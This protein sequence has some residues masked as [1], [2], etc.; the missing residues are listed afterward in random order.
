MIKYKELILEN[1]VQE[2]LNK[3]ESDIFVFK[4]NNDSDHEV[5]YNNN[6]V[7]RWKKKK[8][9][10]YFNV[11]E[12]S[13]LTIVEQVFKQYSQ[14]SNHWNEDTLKEHAEK[15]WRLIIQKHINEKILYIEDQLHD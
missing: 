6:I 9:K 3:N 12:S 10:H 2:W 1:I 15:D 11:I 8:L 4:K 7:A 5:V 14:N 13:D